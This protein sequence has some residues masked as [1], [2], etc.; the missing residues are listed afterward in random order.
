[1][2][3]IKTNFKG[4]IKIQNKIYNDY[5]GYF[6]EIWNKRIEKI[7]KK[8][9]VQENISFS[10]RI[11]TFR[12]FHFQK[13]PFA[14]GKLIWV[15]SGEILD[16]VLN[17]NPNSKF[18]GKFIKIKLKKNDQLWIPPQY[19]HGFLTTKN[20]TLINYKVTRPYNLKKESGYSILDTKLKIF[21][22]KFIRK[23][24]LSK[25]DRM[26]KFLYD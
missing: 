5:R 11:N 3:I 9:F 1:M 2:K 15:L 12:G 8:K 4:V 7:I 20:N 6:L 21:T 24:I 17:I 25:K 23:L 18:F 19:A 13:K 16:I 14:Q 22:K 10:K 26:L